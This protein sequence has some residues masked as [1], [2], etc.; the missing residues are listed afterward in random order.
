[1]IK[2]VENIKRIDID[3][4]KDLPNWFENLLKN[5]STLQIIQMHTSTGY[6]L[7]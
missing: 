1:M 5:I 4:L 3:K 6:V 7:C 2:V